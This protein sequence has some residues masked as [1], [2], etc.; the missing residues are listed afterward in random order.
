MAVENDT[1]DDRED[2][3]FLVSA[4]ILASRSDRSIQFRDVAIAYQQEKYAAF[5]I[6]RASAAEMVKAIA[7]SI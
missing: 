1:A 7:Q 6:D 4:F 5:V 2:L 3:L